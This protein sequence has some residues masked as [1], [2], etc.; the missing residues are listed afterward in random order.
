MEHA[1]GFLLPQ[2]EERPFSA[3]FRGC[4]EIERRVSRAG[5]RSAMGWQVKWH[6]H[7]HTTPPKCCHD[8]LH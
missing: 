6:G 4:L 3:C 1:K 2:K 5:R 7:H 8:D